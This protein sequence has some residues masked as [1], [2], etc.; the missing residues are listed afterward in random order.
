MSSAKPSLE[1]I[2][3]FLGVGAL[4]LLGIFFIID[5]FTNFWVTVEQYARTGS[6]AILFTVP[7]LVI[8]YVL[9][10]LASL[11]VQ[12][13]IERL[14]PPVLSPGLFAAA[15]QK[16]RE[17]LLNR[18]LEVERHSRL[19]YGCTLAFLLLAV[20]SLAVQKYLPPGQELVAVA[21]F[22]IGV[23]MAS[24]CPVL[25]RR[26]QLQVSLYV[27]AFESRAPAASDA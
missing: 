20:G 22:V 16:H 2:T 13:L 25:A 9:G 4:L 15:A 12:T 7:L 17:P 1:E 23:A 21:C 6:F 3:G 24:A 18:Y 11:T 5:G 8:S 14:L 26:L 27:D 19:L 10:L